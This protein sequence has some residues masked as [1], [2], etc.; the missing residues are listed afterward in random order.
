VK[1]LADLTLKRLDSFLEMTTRCISMYADS[2][3][4]IDATWSIAP[5]C[6]L[7]HYTPQTCA[8]EWQVRRPR[9]RD[10]FE[11]E[12]EWLPCCHIFLKWWK[13]TAIWSHMSGQ[14]MRYLG[15]PWSPCWAVATC[16]LV[17]VARYTMVPILSYSSFL[18]ADPDVF[19]SS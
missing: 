18:A 14:R 11:G 3:R 19:L 16:D 7:P 6:R 15:N 12:L 10:C 8:V 2:Q 4:C 17:L 1:G 13:D 5:R 9:Q